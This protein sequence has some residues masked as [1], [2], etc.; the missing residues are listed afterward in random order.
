MN[1]QPVSRDVNPNEVIQ[2][3]QNIVGNL[4]GPN[5]RDDTTR[6]S[7]QDNIHQNP[8]FFPFGTIGLGG[9]DG[10]GGHP[11]GGRFTFTAVTNGPNRDLDNDFFGYVFFPFI[12]VFPKIVFWL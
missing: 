7:G 8:A 10:D 5:V 11:I 1:G 3:F 9:N 6:R 2:D 12:S 4:L